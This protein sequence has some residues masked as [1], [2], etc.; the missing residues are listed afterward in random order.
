MDTGRELFSEGDIVMLKSN[1]PEMAVNQDEG[2][3]VVAQWFSG[4]KL[5]YGRFSP[6]QL[7]LI[8]RTDEDAPSDAPIAG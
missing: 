6:G 1:G 4:K 5:E 3:V 7:K 2:T 8:R